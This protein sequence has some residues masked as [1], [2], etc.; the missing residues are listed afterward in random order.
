MSMHCAK[1]IRAKRSKSSNVPLLPSRMLEASLI[2]FKEAGEGWV[3]A[4]RAKGF[5]SDP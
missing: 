5:I 4:A 3:E 2:K 1:A